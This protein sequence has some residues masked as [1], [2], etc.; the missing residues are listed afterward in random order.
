MALLVHRVLNS[1]IWFTRLTRRLVQSPKC[2]SVAFRHLDSRHKD[3]VGL[4]VGK[5]LPVRARKVTHIAFLDLETK[6]EVA[7][8]GSRMTSLQ[9]EIL[10]MLH[11]GNGALN[12]KNAVE[13]KAYQFYL[14]LYA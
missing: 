8:A 11:F 6:P 10:C 13:Y 9:N 1:T 7:Q 5:P 12:S 14:Q 2:Q 4:P 3:L